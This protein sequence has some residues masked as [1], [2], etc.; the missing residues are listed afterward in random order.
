[1]FHSLIEVWVGSH[2]LCDLVWR[3]FHVD[4]MRLQIQ[5]HGVPMGSPWGPHGGPLGDSMG[6]PHGVPMGTPW[7]P[8]EGCF[9]LHKTPIWDTNRFNRFNYF[10]RFGWHQLQHGTPLQHAPG[11]RTTVVTQN[12]LELSLF[13]VLLSHVFIHLCFSEHPLLSIRGCFHC[14]FVCQIRDVN[15]C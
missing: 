8:Q 11:V 3:L 13:P 7:I 15:C 9:Y 2:S 4:W 5:I 14:F 12:P 6:S 10:N 1:M